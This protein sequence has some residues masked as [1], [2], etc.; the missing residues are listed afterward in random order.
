MVR[1]CSADRSGCD[2]DVREHRN[3]GPSLGVCGYRMAEGLRDRSKVGRYSRNKCLGTT[4]TW[5][6]RS[7]D[8]RTVWRA[9]F[10]GA[11]GSGC[12]NSR[13]AAAPEYSSNQGHQDRAFN[14]TRISKKPASEGSHPS[15]NSGEAATRRSGRSSIKNSHRKHAC[16]PAGSIL[17]LFPT[18]IPP[19]RYRVH[20]TERDLPGYHAHW[21]IPDD[22]DPVSP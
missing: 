6:L 8:E 1:T 7:N 13:G 16:W 14:C 4:E 12:F 9:L 17:Q 22:E 20:R 19:R 5:R 10:R 11:Q 21:H 3:A 18:L 15:Q 2:R